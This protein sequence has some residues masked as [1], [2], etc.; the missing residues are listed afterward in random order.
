MTLAAAFTTLYEKLEQLEQAFENLLWAVVQ[1]QPAGEEGHALVDHY[2]A[3]SSDVVGW[4]HEAKVAVAV[5]CRASPG[6]LDLAYIRQALT[7]CQERYNQLSGCFHGDIGAFD[8][9]DALNNLAR[10]RGG[11]WLQWVQGVRDALN[12]CPQPLYEV[13]QALFACWLELTEWAGLPL[14]PVQTP[15]TEQAV[16]DAER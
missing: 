1:G 9:I 10:E 4:L 8:W 12:R 3:A 6:Q 5:G 13:S 15:S 14:V 11:G 16:P 7:T 2:E